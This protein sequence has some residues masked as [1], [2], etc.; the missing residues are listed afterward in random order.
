MFIEI[1]TFSFKFQYLKR[2]QCLHTGQWRITTPELSGFNLRKRRMI[3]SM[4]M[5]MTTTTTILVRQLDAGAPRPP[6]CLPRL[7][8]LPP[9]TVSP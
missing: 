2:S 1:I 5:M 6:Q 3:S 7:H 4:K 8:R 9:L